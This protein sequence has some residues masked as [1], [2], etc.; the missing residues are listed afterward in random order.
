MPTDRRS[1]NIHLPIGETGDCR[2][3][4]A[5]PTECAV[6]LT[7]RECAERLRLSPRTLE[8][9][10][11]EGRGPRYVKAG[12]G[13][14]SRVLYCEADLAAWVEAQRFTSTCEYQSSK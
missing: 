12:P 6:L 13:S 8:R 11:V 9:M 7:T 5:V 10:R 1:P 3:N 4:R 14:Q 2:Q